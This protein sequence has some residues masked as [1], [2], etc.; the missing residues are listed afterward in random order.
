MF[1]AFI[2]TVGL[3]V[4]FGSQNYR[5]NQLCIFKAW[6]YIYLPLNFIKHPLLNKPIFDCKAVFVYNRINFMLDGLSFTCKP[7]THIY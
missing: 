1:V 3:S 5:L 4:G 2:P 6:A 7:I